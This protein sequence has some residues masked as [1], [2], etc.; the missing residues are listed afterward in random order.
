M[1]KLPVDVRQLRC[2]AKTAAGQELR[3]LAYP[4]EHPRGRQAGQPPWSRHKGAC[5]RLP[6]TTMPIDNSKKRKVLEYRRGERK[7]RVEPGNW[8]RHPITRA[9]RPPVG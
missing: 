8:R 6:H 9:R 4:R 2:R 7:A 1:A 5:Y 3:V